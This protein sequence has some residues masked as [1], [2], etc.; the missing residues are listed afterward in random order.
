M[1]TVPNQNRVTWTYRLYRMKKP[2]RTYIECVG[3]NLYEITPIN[4]EYIKRVEKG[5]S[6]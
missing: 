1:N 3:D 6:K 4:D 5:E 2:K